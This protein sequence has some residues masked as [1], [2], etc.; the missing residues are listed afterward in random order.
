MCLGRPAWP[1]PPHGQD[2][3]SAEAGPGCFRP[4]RTLAFRPARTLALR[5]GLRRPAW[6]GSLAVGEH[7]CDGCSNTQDRGDKFVV[8]ERSF[9]LSEEG[10]CVLA[11]YTLAVAGQGK[12][13][14]RWLGRIPRPTP[15]KTLPG[16]P[17]KWRT[18][19]RLRSW[20]QRKTSWPAFATGGPG[21]PQGV[22]EAAWTGNGS[23]KASPE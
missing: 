13:C 4:A 2:T 14:G 20:P 22:P 15:G 23:A 6:H 5:P 9:E 3:T 21:R 18:V 7:C 11:T 17:G 10:S 1:G 16:H 19:A 12:A 8:A